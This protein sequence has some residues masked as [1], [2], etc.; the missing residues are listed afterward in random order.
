M[1]SCGYY[2]TY[3]KKTFSHYTS[4]GEKVFN[5]YEICKKCQ[6]VLRNWTTY[7]D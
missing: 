4:K 6:K 2:G 5:C 7:G 1:C 3:I